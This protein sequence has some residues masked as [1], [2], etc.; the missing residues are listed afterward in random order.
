MSDT[1]Q[2]KPKKKKTGRRILR[3]LILL[4]IIAGIAVGA[5]YFIQYRR[6]HIS[7]DDAYV[8]GHIHWISPRIPG[9]VI[10]VLIDDNQLVKKGQVL[11][12]LDPAT[13]QTRLAQAEA[14]LAVAKTKLTEARVQVAVIAS[15][16]TLN[17][18]EYNNALL[19]FNRAKLAYPNKVISKQQYDHYMTAY[20]V[21]LA[22]L[23]TSQQRLRLARDQVKSAMAQI[24][25]WKAK[26]KDAKLNLG[27]TRVLAPVNGYVTKKTVEVGARVGPQTPLFAIVPLNDVW[28][29]ANYKENQL[30]RVRVGQD[31]AI[32]ISTYPGVKFRGKVE[33][34][35]AG[36]GAVFSLFPP[37]NATGN[38]VK[39]TQRI[40]VKI[41]ILPPFK[42]VLRIGMSAETTILVK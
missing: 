38:W 26:V 36:T 35:Q 21:A 25:V 23:A 29:E 27:Y 22:K 13:Y 39:I 18:A 40:P 17:K 10:N 37:E 20:K 3:I 1:P 28:I 12:E 11:V 19:D 42:K 30:A 6:T 33:S 31:V 34:I 5:D 41:R 14:G 32:T 16:I 7:T 15:E 8:K 4:I 2:E 24:R 9:T